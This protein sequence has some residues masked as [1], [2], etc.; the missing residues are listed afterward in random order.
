MNRRQ[1]L[2]AAAALPGLS[3]AAPRLAS[4]QARA[5]V[6]KY[7]PS[8][9]LSVLDP[10]FTTAFVTRNH[11]CMVYDTLYGVDEAQRPQPQMAEGHVIEN[12]GK[13]WR[14][15]LR[16]G[17]RFHDGEPV[18]ARDAAASLKRWASRD[19]YGVTL[20]ERVDELSASSD[21]ELVFRLKR[22]FPHL[23]D[24]LGKP[25][26]CLPAIMPERLANTPSTTQVSEIVGSGPFRFMANERISGA[27]AVYQRFEDYVPRSSGTTSFLAGPKIAHFDRVEWHTQP[28]AGT[29]ASALQTGEIDWWEQPLADL[30]PV[31]K[32]NPNIKTD[33]LQT[34]GYLAVMRFNH[35]VPPFDRPEMRRALFAGI[36]QSDY[37][38]AV[39]G[40]DKSRWRDG[41]G[42]FLPDSPMAS[43]VGMEALTSPRSISAVKEALKKAGYNGERVV[44]LSSVDSVLTHPLGEV[45]A[46]YL[47][48]AGLNIDFQTQDWGSIWGRLQSRKPVDQGGW[49]I[50]CNYTAG[51]SASNPAAYSYMR[52]TGT[53][54]LFGWPTSPKIEA[55]RDAWLDAS[56]L[57]EQ[58]RICRDIQ[59][60]AFDEVPFIPL[61]LFY[62]ATAYRKDLVDM[63][64]GLPLFYGVRR[65]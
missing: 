11:A 32:S 55:L 23:P 16:K 20:M 40:E 51:L 6:L 5:R 9:D 4:A 45:G 64:K 8:T 48:E 37:M 30:L 56:D 38:M 1:F 53:S 46:A 57:A 61:G 12:D 63:P 10:M 19:P 26:P 28:D 21:R 27:L 33:I 29:A 58:Q 13:T 52:G 3:L 2:A 18:L 25:T 60:Q 41:V 49:N 14:I 17:L 42:Y 39:A 47:R 34:D 62:Q 7:A 43:K 22:P 35:M 31:L 65:A 54:A 44:M 24:V 59:A 50:H 36:Q 15:T